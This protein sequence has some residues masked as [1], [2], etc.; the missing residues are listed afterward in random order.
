MA[1]CDDICNQPDLRFPA[2]NRQDTAD[3]PAVFFH[4]YLFRTSSEQIRPFHN[5]S[6]KPTCWDNCSCQ[7]SKL[8]FIPPVYRQDIIKPVCYVM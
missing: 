7:R 3:D 2:Y 4:L 8:L 1:A 6:D 5:P